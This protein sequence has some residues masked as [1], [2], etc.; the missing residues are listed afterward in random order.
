VQATLSR[1]PAKGD[2]VEIPEGVLMVAAKDGYRVDRIRFEPS[3]DG[4]A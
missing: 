1:I 3:R 4:D 2:A